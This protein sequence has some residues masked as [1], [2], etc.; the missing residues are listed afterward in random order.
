[1]AIRPRFLD[2]LRVE[3]LGDGRWTL[4][5]DLRYQSARAAA[6][7]VVPAGFVTD[8]ASVPRLPFVFW[9][10]GDAAHAPATVHDFLYQTH[11]LGRGAADDVFAEAMEAEGVSAW[12]RAMMWAGVRAGGTSAYESGPDR[13]VRLN[14]GATEPKK[15]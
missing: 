7:F 3:E 5:A 1:M 15:P 8:F 4:L 2:P 13:Y 10:C 9:L 11:L 14:K 12:R 6:L